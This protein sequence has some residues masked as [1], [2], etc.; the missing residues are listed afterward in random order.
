M[1]YWSRLTVSLRMLTWPGERG[2]AGPGGHDRAHNVH[3][4][5]QSVFISRHFSGCF[6]ANRNPVSTLL[7][8]EL[9]P[10]LMPR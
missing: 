7:I 9:I 1:K 4:K 6:P 8:P 10:P 2:R 3:E 5:K